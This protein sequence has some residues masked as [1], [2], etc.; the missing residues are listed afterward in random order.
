VSNDNGA[1]WTEALRVIN[2]NGG[3]NYPSTPPIVEFFKTFAP[4]T[5]TDI[6]LVTYK[7]GTTNDT[8]SR[9][10][11][12]DLQFLE[13][14]PSALEMGYQVIA[15][16]PEFVSV[17]AFGASEALDDNSP[18]IQKA[19]DKHRNVLIPDGVFKVQ[20]SIKVPSNTH[21]KM[22]KGTEIRRNADIKSIFIN[23]STGTIGGYDAN[24]NITI[25]GGMI[26]GNYSAFATGT[27]REFGQIVFAHTKN[28]VIRG[29]KFKNQ[30]RWHMIEVNSSYNILIE[31]CKFQDYIYTDTNATEAIQIDYA[32]AAGLPMAE[33]APYDETMCQNITIR[34][35]EFENVY[36]AIGSHSSVVGK[37]HRKIKVDNCHFKNL[38][39]YVI[40][41]VNWEDV[42]FVNN[43][44]EGAKYGVYLYLNGTKSG[45]IRIA[46]NRLYTIGVVAGVYDNVARAIQVS[47]A[48]TGV[49]FFERVMI[50]N[51]FISGVGRYG[52]G[53]DYSQNVS[54]KSNTVQAIYL[55]GIW[56]YGA[57]KV[58]ITD[59]IVEN[60]NVAA[61]AQ[62]QS[63]KVGAADGTDKG[64]IVQGNR[65]E[66]VSV[67]TS[68][69]VALLYNIINTAGTYLPATN[70]N[71]QNVGNLFI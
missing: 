61:A 8:A 32:A 59:N 39:G 3:V 1:T 65:M 9:V 38:T 23:K 68:D 19:L 62:T 42:D 54:V 10:Q 44:V 60:T 15:Q 45:R 70:T 69:N 40:T 4:I 66:S 31:N 48:A 34:N 18:A 55:T 29:V 21:L 30:D 6:K 53:F 46:N 2:N 7:K 27:T 58:F 47:S 16:K 17:V 64:V 37:L 11:I 5:G 20:Q 57:K 63:I 36:H 51:N 33:G 22:S 50:E 43:L 67:E 12:Y 52:I 14:D 13:A 26:N 41:A 56:S 24:E 35:C 28:S 25:E 71:F 49:A